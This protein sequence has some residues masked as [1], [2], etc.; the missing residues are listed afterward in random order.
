V[1]REIFEATHDQY[2]SMVR[3][4][5][6]REVV[7]NFDKWEVDGH[8]SREF[9]HAAGERGIL[10]IPIP[11]DFGG[12]G[13]SDYRYNVVLQEEVARAFVSLGSFRTH[14][15]VVLPYFL[16]LANDEQRRRWLPGI[17]RGEI[18]TAIAMTEPSAGSDL[19]GITTS[20]RRDGDDYIVNGSKTFITG[21][22]LADLVIVI[23]RTAHDPSN[24]RNGLTLLVI[25]N[26]TPGFSKGRLLSKLGLKAQDTVELSFQEVRVRGERARS[27]RC[28]IRIPR[29]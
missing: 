10:G 1:R 2:R 29:K 6:A 13:D 23:V 4:F 16:R 28:R 25:E 21:G 22:L 19:S 7:P 12:A 3:E 8:V 9:I 26:G 18:F 14:T 11:V 24:R 15:D 27:R 20:A 17:A 5:V